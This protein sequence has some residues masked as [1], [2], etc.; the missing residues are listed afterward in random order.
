MSD[1]FQRFPTST[2]TQVLAAASCILG[3]WI[4]TQFLQ[5]LRMSRATTPLQGPPSTSR[6]LGLSRVIQASKDSASLYKQWAK[7]YGL[8]YRVPYTLGADRIILNDPKAIAHFYAHETFT[9]VRSSFARRG[10]D[11]LVGR[12]LLWAEGDSHRRWAIFC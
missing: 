4:I 5:F 10:V 8:V 7:E 6:I 12:G 11:R 2:S 3:A 9:Y 1:L